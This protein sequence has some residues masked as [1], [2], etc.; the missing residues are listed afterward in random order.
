MCYHFFSRLHSVLKHNHDIHFRKALFPQNDN[1]N[2]V[3]FAKGYVQVTGDLIVQ[4]ESLRDTNSGFR[5]LGT[6]TARIQA[7]KM[8]EHTI[9]NICKGILNTD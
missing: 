4:K 6:T 8:C 7:T 1:S 5:E 3:V 9:D 2:Q